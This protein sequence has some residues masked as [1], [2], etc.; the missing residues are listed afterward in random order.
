MV[1]IYV[2]VYVN[3]SGAFMRGEPF[4]LIENAFQFETFWKISLL[5]EC[6][7]ITDKDRAVK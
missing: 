7:T 2:P 6:F 4:I 5:H 1:G 3:Y